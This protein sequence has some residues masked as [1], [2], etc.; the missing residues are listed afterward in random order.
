MGVIY[1][2]KTAPSRTTN[3]PIKGDGSWI[4]N[5]TLQYYIGR[6]KVGSKFEL[7]FESPH[8]FYYGHA[9]DANIYGWVLPHALD[10]K[11]PG[12]TI[13]DSLPPHSRHRFQHRRSVGK[14]FNAAP[15]AASDGTHVNVKKEGM[16]YYNYFSGRNLHGGHWHTP[17]GKLKKTDYIKYRFTTYDGHRAVVIKHKD[18][19]WCFAPY[20]YIE[21]PAKKNLNNDND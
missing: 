12:K 15:H 4:M 11:H 2:V 5:S 9:L 14:D 10:L 3:Q 8:H 19:G 7:I 20:D 13:H 21:L 6:A 16:L 17:A 18:F 1:N